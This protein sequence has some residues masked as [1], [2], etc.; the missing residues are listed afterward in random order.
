MMTVQ[1]SDEPNIP[2]Q[3]LTGDLVLNSLAVGGQV[4]QTGNGSSG[5]HAVVGQVKVGK[6]LGEVLL[7]DLRMSAGLRHLDR[8]RLTASGNWAIMMDAVV[9]SGRRGRRCHR[10]SV[11][12]GMKG[13]SSLRPAS[14]Q[15]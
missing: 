1:V 6:R 9:S 14:R 2:M 3:K 8:G 5:L 10:S 7:G 11:T 15:V 4:V 13:W 12:Y